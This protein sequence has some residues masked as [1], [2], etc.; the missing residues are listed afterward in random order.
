MKTLFW[1]WSRFCITGGFS[2]FVQF[3]IL[4]AFVEIFSMKPVWASTGGYVG[5]S[6]INYLLNHYFTFRSQLPHKQAV[7]RFSVNSL[8]GLVLN[9]FIMRFFLLHYRYLLSQIL[10]SAAVLVWNFLIHQCWTFRVKKMP[11]CHTQ[12]KHSR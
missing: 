1:Q 6:L 8:F 3:C 12:H 4:I 10:T 9:F 2:A 11:S 5:G 7:F